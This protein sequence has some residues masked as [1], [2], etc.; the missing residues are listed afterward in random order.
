MCRGISAYVHAMR[1]M[2]DRDDPAGYVIVEADLK[3]MSASG[4]LADGYGT[5]S[6]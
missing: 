1:L 4:A 2:L 3:L 5:E 6:W